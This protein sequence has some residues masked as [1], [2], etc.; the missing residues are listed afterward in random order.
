VE[1][2]EG[3]GKRDGWREGGRAGEREEGQ[4]RRGGIGQEAGSRKRGDG[5]DR[6]GGAKIQFTALKR[7]AHPRSHHTPKVLLVPTPLLL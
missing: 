3:Q 7:E 5:R 1:V 6:G 4:K 2:D